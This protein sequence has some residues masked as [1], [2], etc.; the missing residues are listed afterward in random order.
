MFLYVI[1]KF[2]ILLTNQLLLLVIVMFKSMLKSITILEL[3]K[4]D[5]TKASYNHFME[6]KKAGS[7]LIMKT[8]LVT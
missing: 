5:F 8:D 2:M 7:Y 3:I 4:P 1:N 6:L